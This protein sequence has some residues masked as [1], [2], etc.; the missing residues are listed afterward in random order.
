MENIYPRNH[1]YKSFEEQIDILTKR[2]LEIDDRALAME[3]IQSFSYYSIINGY[4]DLFTEP[5][6]ENKFISGTTFSMLYQVHWIDLSMSSIIFKYTL[7]VEKKLKT[8]VANLV[9]QSFSIEDNSYLNER[10]YSTSKPQ[11]GKLKDVITAIDKAKKQDISVIHYMNEENNIPPW[12][13][14][15][16]ISFG[17]TFNWYSILRPPHKEVII[18]SFLGNTYPLSGDSRMELFKI[19]IGQVYEYR[20]LSAHGNRNF[21][22]KFSQKT[23]YPWRYLK[24]LKIQNFFAINDNPANQDNF[25]SAILSI[26]LLINDPYVCRNLIIEIEQF[27]Q[28]YNIP[29]F[30]F[31]NKNIFQLFDIPEDIICRL[32]LLYDWKFS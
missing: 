27:I 19:A 4:K 20:N 10:N 11:K 18:K 12:I 32:N 13:A 1:P 25:F 8:Q 6:N 28:T 31:L 3:A 29:E 5:S 7:A 22:L 26:M 23:K 30:T 21:K 17:S 9:A 2:N 14:A 16:A 15:K 24:D